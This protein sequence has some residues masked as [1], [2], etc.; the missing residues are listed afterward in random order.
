MI[1]QDKTFSVYCGSGGG[2]AR[3]LQPAPGPTAAQTPLQPAP[4]QTP[5][6]P[7]P[8]PTAASLRAEEQ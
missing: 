8:G 7:A 5:L 4:G 3:P 6:Q 1:S 2:T